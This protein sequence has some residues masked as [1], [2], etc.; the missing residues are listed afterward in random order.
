MKGYRS[1]DYDPFQ[2]CYPESELEESFER[3]LDMGSL[4]LADDMAQ[5]QLDEDDPVDEHQNDLK[6][7]RDSRT[8]TGS[9][10][11]AE[12]LKDVDRTSED[13]VDDFDE[14]H[15]TCYLKEV[16]AYPLLTPEMEIELAKRI[17]DGQDALV[18]LVEEHATAHP[19]LQ[20]LKAKVDT[21]LS[22]EKSF[23]GVRDKIL[24]VISRTLRQACNDHPEEPLFVRLR[25][26]CDQIMARIDEAKHHM[27]KANLRLVLSIAKKYRGRGMSFDDLIQEGNLGLMKAV[28]RY[29]HTKGNRFS[30]YATWWVRQSIIRG[31]YDKTRTIRLPVHF[32][33]LKNLFFKVFHE[34]VKELGREPTPEEISQRANIPEEK[35]EMVLNLVSQPLSLEMP[36]GEDEQR[37]CDFIEDEESESPVEGCEAH[38][39]AE[40]TR[41]LLASLQ[42]REEKILRLRFGLNG[43]PGETLEK[44]GKNFK[45][46][47]ERIRQ[48]EKKALR[49]LRHPS[50]QETLKPYLE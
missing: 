12:S 35:V 42:P 3:L 33:E 11:S 17:R 30:T 38:E 5:D 24:K 25:E 4:G 7:E 41:E 43:R 36:V 45:V 6:K 22:Q 20:D 47:K 39:L 13:P 48:I 46:S 16:S 2:K 26:E 49:K 40:L 31:I 44:I 10:E 34:L 29:D 19:V 1:D 32:I 37:L 14:D 23:P 8:L 50:K 9:D 27:V 15:V 18:R 21:L 28:G